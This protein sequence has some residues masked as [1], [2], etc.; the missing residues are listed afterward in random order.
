MMFRPLAVFALVCGCSAGAASS[1]DPPVSVRELPAPR[2][3]NGE[4]ALTSAPS[5]EPPGASSARPEVAVASVTSLPYAFARVHEL[6]A[7]SIAAGKP[8]KVAVLTQ[9]EVLIFD[10]K[11]SRR[12]AVPETSDET[13]SIEIFFGRDD[14]PRLMGYRRASDPSRAEPYYRRYKG[15]RFRPEPS[16]LG[17]LAAPDGALYGVL[18]H[19]DPEVVCRPGQFCL[20]KRTSGWGRA[21]AHSEPVRVFLSGGTAWALHRDRIEHLEHDAWVPLA[22]EHAWSEPVSLFVSPDGA[23]WVLEAKRDFLTHLVKDRWEATPSPIDGPRAI[24]GSAPNDIWLV[25]TGG[26]AHFDGSSW[27]RVPGVAGPLHLIGYSAPNLW[28]AGKAGVY[29]GTPTKPE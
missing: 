10:A 15:D 13:I 3:S 5:D 6:P 28:L 26:A 24:A 20:V 21:P 8:P 23:P 27:L 4:S 7:L 12:V 11:G 25:G 17:P 22:P 14:Q 9:G 19:A 1:H 29:R 2:S 18:G 16:E